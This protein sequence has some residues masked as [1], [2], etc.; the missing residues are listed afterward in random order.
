MRIVMTLLVR[1]EEDIVGANIA[2]HLSQGVDFIIATDNRSE[3]E[4]AK[5]LQWY[6]RQGVL[7]YIYEEADDYSQGIWVTRMARLAHAEHYAD[8]VINNDADE[9]WWP[10][11][12]SLHA[13]LQ[14]MPMYVDRVEVQRHNF[15]AV[16]TADPFF[17]SMV[18]RE[19]RSLNA[20]GQPL[21]PKVMHRG[22]SQVI[23]AQGNHA[24]EGM[25]GVQVPT[26]EI[27]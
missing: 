16:E 17:A 4:T 1:N 13:V 24:A 12:G 8:W 14:Q 3:D 10:A 22:S 20:L 9:F 7:R 25:G 6:A 23:V 2:Y 5:I 18:Y 26:N 15:V 19:T 27:E 21:P 11:R